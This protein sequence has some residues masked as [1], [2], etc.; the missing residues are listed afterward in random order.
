MTFSKES[1]NTHSVWQRKVARH[2]C[3]ANGGFCIAFLSRILLNLLCSSTQTMFWCST[4][5]LQVWNIINV[6]SMRLHPWNGF[7]RAMH[8]NFPPDTAS[9]I[10][11]LHD[12]HHVDIC[13]M[14][15]GKFADE[16]AFLTKISA[17]ISTTFLKLFHSGNRVPHRSR[18]NNEIPVNRFG[19]YHRMG[20]VKYSTQS[21]CT[22]RSHFHGPPNMANTGIWAANGWR[23]SHWHPFLLRAR[24]RC[25]EPLTISR[26]IFCENYGTTAQRTFGFALGSKRSIRS[27]LAGEH[28]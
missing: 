2:E 14:C 1:I 10:Q 12:M 5:N 4:D 21:S 28:T 11:Y 22:Y 3:A 6:I 27:W 25:Y 16:R 13:Y 20:S 8:N 19:L 15:S 24:G 23:A 9:V 26:L 18:H 17:K 7:P